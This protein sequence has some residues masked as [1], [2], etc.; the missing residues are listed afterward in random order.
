MLYD[1]KWDTRNLRTLV[2]WLMT[3]DPCTTYD[4]D[5]VRD[6]LIVRHLR[7]SGVG[8]GHFEDPML[9]SYVAGEEPH[10]Y[11]AALGRALETLERGEG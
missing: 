4:F 8:Y 1:P 10:T 11:G 5:D 6:C 3:Q 2:D 9:R 7:G